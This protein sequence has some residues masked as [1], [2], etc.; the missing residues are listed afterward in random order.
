MAKGC[1]KRLYSTSS[2]FLSI[3]KKRKGGG[4]V[5]DY[6]VMNTAAFGIAFVFH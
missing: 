5:E 4:G 1:A 3:L 2:S 6:R